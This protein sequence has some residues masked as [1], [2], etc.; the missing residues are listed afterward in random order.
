MTGG[1]CS[2]DS[3]RMEAQLSELH[4][5]FPSSSQR[6]SPQH[7]DLLPDLDGEIEDRLVQHRVLSWPFDLSDDDDLLRVRPSQAPNR[8]SPRPTELVYQALPTDFGSQ[9]IDHPLPT[10]DFLFQDG[11]HHNPLRQPQSLLGPSPSSARMS[12][13]D[14]MDF[15]P[16]A[17]PNSP[18]GNGPRQV[19]T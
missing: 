16:V 6:V 1:V 15:P 19:C 2:Y 3:D 12:E 17:L 4:Q 7:P 5:Q 18:L 11:L 8:I 10:Q 9:L 13:V 14:L